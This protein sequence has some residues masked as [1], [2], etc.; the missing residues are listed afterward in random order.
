MIKAERFLFKLRQHRLVFIIMTVHF[1]LLLLGANKHYL[2]GDEAEN[3]LY[4]KS[5]LSN[6]IPYAWD[7]TNIMG[8]YNGTAIND[9]LLNNTSPWAYYYLTALFFK[10]FGIST[11]T[12]RLPFIILS[13]ITLY[14]VYKLSFLVTNNRQTSVI[15][16][17]YLSFNIPYILFAYQSR[18][19]A[20]TNLMTVLFIYYSLKL[21]LKTNMG[22]I[23]KLAISGIIFFHSQYLSLAAF[24]PA[25]LFSLFIF[26]KPYS[27]K[28]V[29]KIFFTVF[30]I[31]CFTLP[32]LIIMHPNSNQGLLLGNFNIRNGVELSLRYFNDL[33]ENSSLP[34]LLSVVFLW[35][36]PLRLT[37]AD[38]KKVFYIIGVVI[39]YI[40]F[41]SFLSTQR[42]EL[43]PKSYLRYAVNIFPLTAVIVA[44]FI[45]EV[46]KRHKISGLI[47]F[48]LITFTNIFSLKFPP[49]IWL[50]DY[51]SE[52]TNKN[53]VSSTEASVKFLTDKV[54]PGDTIFVTPDYN[55]EPLQFYLKN[56]VKFVNR[57]SPNNIRLI[58]RKN[59]F[60][61]G[62]IYNFR[63]SPD[64]IV[65]FG[66]KE[67][68]FNWRK[69]P[70][71]TDLN[72]Y[73]ENRLPV[74][75]Y[76]QTRPEISDHRFYP[77]TNFKED[78]SVFIY[79]L[80]N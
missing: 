24:L 34:V 60:L 53:Y 63:E 1:L 62:Y 39:F 17:I 27:K 18:Y 67:N 5:I 77:L 35:L 25:S 28:I 66:K 33:S 38:S 31:G 12:A 80:I 43:T 48:I 6:G 40:I 44:V 20:L 30:I 76:D 69:L 15:A 57:I 3:A 19:F 42:I 8:L 58:N 7:G 61:P 73:K 9:K 32:W 36:Y 74:Y 2:W 68:V 22:N 52:M 64:W 10:I 78:E 37:A 45:S 23:G 47:F 51:L 46:L 13:L 75:M 70:A 21:I 79:Q 59:S 50:I 55:V 11:F 65:M 16:I 29:S 14:F 71:N 56:G 41:L 72:R 26:S 4:A 49:S 54:R